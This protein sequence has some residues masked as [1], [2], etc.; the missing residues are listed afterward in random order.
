M[1]ASDVGGIPEV[2]IDDRTGLLVPVDDVD[3][4]AAAAIALATDD[5]RREAFSAAGVER[6]R[7]FG[8]ERQVDAYLDWYDEIAVR[9]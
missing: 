4:L 5:S 6:A 1:V 2:V 9:P 7:E 3:A 8:I